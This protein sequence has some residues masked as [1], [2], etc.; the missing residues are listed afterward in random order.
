M[1]TNFSSRKT[2]SRYPSRPCDPLGALFTLNQ[3][4]NTAVLQL[5]TDTYRFRKFNQVQYL[6]NRVYKYANLYKG[7]SLPLALEFLALVD[8]LAQ[9]DQVSQGYPTSQLTNTDP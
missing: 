3:T 6:L 8:L 4:Q 2:F 7:H 1:E 9:M 5:L